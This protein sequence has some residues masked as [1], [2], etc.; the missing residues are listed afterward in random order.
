MKPRK[1]TR[2]NAIYT[3]CLCGSTYVQLAHA[4]GVSE[5]RVDQIFQAEARRRHPAI[6]ESIARGMGFRARFIEAL[7]MQG[8]PA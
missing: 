5:A 8:V 4:H 6:F 7:K 2:N 1:E 3:A